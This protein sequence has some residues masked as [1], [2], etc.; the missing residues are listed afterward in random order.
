MAD[1]PTTPAFP[2]DNSL[3]ERCGYPLK[4]LASDASCPECGQAVA[5]SSPALRRG[6]QYQFENKYFRL[7]EIIFASLFDTKSTSREMPIDGSKWNDRLILL[8]CA[9]M[10]G[11]AWSSLGGMAIEG[12][13]RNAHWLDRLVPLI[14]ITMTY[15]EILGV[16]AFSRR[17]GWRVPFALAERVCC[18]AAVGWVPGLLIAGAGMW[19]LRWTAFGQLWFDSLLG[20]VRVSWLFF[21]GLFVL[22]FL[23][24]ET[25]VWIGVRQVRYANAW[26]DMPLDPTQDT[27]QT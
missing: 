19:V 14:V 13:Y 10:A 27:P 1:P 25:L 22:S 4:G 2:T 8:L 9:L 18:R 16:T 3:C 6:V 12:V 21:L 15:V 7:L 26:P 11:S 5:E 24:F 23:W 20:L 17:R